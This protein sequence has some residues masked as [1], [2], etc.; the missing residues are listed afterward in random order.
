MDST[1]TAD[2]PDVQNQQGNRGIALT[3]QITNQRGLTPLIDP[4]IDLMARAT[5]LDTT[6]TKI[7]SLSEPFTPA[8]HLPLVWKSKNQLYRHPV[9]L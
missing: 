6:L 5:T 4:L 9:A 8:S 7:P 2:V 1:Q 3:S